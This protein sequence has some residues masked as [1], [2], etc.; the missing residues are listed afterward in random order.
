MPPHKIHRSVQ[1]TAIFLALV[2]ALILAHLIFI[3]LAHV[4]SP[5]RIQPLRVEGRWTAVRRSLR[6]PPPVQPKPRSKLP[7]S[8]SSRFDLKRKRALQ[9]SQLDYYDAPPQLYFAADAFT[10]EPFKEQE[11]ALAGP[12]TQRQKSG[13]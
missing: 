6:L 12:K 10:E 7:P 9:D 3:L 2:L 11:A 13:E 1:R 4:Q 8:V 5:S